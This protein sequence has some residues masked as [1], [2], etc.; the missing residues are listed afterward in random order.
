MNRKQPLLLAL[1]AA[2]VIGTSAP[3]FAA[4][5]TDAATREDVISLLWQQ[6]GAP[7]INYALPFTDVADTAADAVRWAAEAKIVSGYG[8]GKFEPNQKITRE[9]LAAIFYRYAAYK[10]YDV[11]VG[12][13]TNILSFADASDITP[14][15]IPA[16][17]WAYG[18]GVF[19]GTEEYVLPSA[20]VAEAEVTTMLKK[21]T[22][23]PAATVVAEIPEESIS[24]VYKGNENFVLTSKDVQ[25]QFQLNCLVDGSYAPTLTLADLNNDGKD[26]IYVIFTVG[27]GSGFHVEGLVAYDKETLEEYFVPDPREIAEPLITEKDGTY[28]LSTKEGVHTFTDLG[29]YG[30]LVFSDMV[31]YRIVEN[32]LTAT[33][34]LQTAPDTACGE[35][36]LTY[37]P[38]EGGFILKEASYL[39][40]K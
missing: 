4:E 35:L 23:P 2:M 12:E 11:S 7:V 34:L 10:G 25:E 18:S 14:Y 24:L 39:P 6:E 36:Q 31:T 8:N 40:S 15:A 37:Q 13:N 16:I 29:S 27:A 22:V 30:K 26:E 33:L 5:A 9:Q 17:Q 3:A 1:S 20:A 38:V 28:Q 19:L 21:V 32:T